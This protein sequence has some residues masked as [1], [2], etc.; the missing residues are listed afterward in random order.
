MYD[1]YHM[2]PK[3]INMEGL[4]EEVRTLLS[5]R[6]VDELDDLGCDDIANSVVLDVD[7]LR[8]LIVH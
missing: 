6:H 2:T 5:R 7:V 3:D 4:G 1:S 8:S